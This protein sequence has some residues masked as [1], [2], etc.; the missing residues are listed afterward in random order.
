MVATAISKVSTDKIEA[1]YTKH[2][3]ITEEIECCRDKYR[4]RYALVVAEKKNPENDPELQKIVAQGVALKEKLNEVAYP[5]T[6][7]E[8]RDNRDKYTAYIALLL[9]WVCGNSNVGSSLNDTQK[10]T[11]STEILDTYGDTTM[12]E[13]GA[14]LRDGLRGKYGDFYRLDATVIHR[15]IE[16]YR[17]DRNQ[18]RRAWRESRHL[19]T[20]EAVR[21][22]IDQL[23]S[24]AL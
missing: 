9:N 15:W 17:E 22:K 6:L 3:E 18:V 7:R 19:S 8:L 20:K 11:L 16:K 5:K 10:L 23:N 21:D 13:I 4:L 2:L 14:V 12:E 24:K 1:R